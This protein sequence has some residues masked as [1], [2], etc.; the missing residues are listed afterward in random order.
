MFSTAFETP[1]KYRL[2]LVFLSNIMGNSYRAD[3]INIESE[4][5]A[6]LFYFF[7][8]TERHAVV[9]IISF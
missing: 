7:K 2:V 9:S 8:H 6:I 4:M 3:N 5:H 1:V